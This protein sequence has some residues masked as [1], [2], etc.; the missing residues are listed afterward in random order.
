MPY[1][2]SQMSRTISGWPYGIPARRTCEDESARTVISEQCG[3][4]LPA[5]E[6]KEREV[7][8]TGVHNGEAVRVGV[9]ERL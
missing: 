7:S 4:G 9:A 3:M 8:G 6:M 5:G 1:C 2:I